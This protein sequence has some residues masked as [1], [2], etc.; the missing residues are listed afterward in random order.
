MLFEYDG[1][2][3]SRRSWIVL[4][5]LVALVVLTTAQV[6]AVVAPTP[7]ELTDAGRVAD[8]EAPTAMIAPASHVTAKSLAPDI[9]FETADGS[10]VRLSDLRGK[11]VLVDFWAAW[12]GPCVEEL[13]HLLQLD[14]ELGGAD[15]EIVGI[16]LNRTEEEFRTF[17]ETH[18]I[19][20]PQRHGPD[21]WEGEAIRAFE[22]KALPSHYL[23]D[24]EG[25]FLRVPLGPPDRLT[26]AVLE[27]IDG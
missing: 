8:A 2:R 6:S 23:I 18:Q 25:N 16:S 1:T 5:G 27:L 3:E 9:E 10:T 24:R 14:R 7:A 13:P 20:W 17:I 4:S 22:L 19:P 26:R 11:V 21:G 15:F 12:C